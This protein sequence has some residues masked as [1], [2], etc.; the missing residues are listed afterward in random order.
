M[1]DHITRLNEQRVK[2][3]T[4]AIGY[5]KGMQDIREIVKAAAKEG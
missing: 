5:G 3:F 4:E 1:V 2:D